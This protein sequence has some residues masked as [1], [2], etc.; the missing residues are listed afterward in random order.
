[1]DEL[2]YIDSW[3]EAAACF[4]RSDVDFFADN[5]NATSRAIETCTGCPV[6]DECLTWALET[7]QRDGVWGGYTPTQRHRIRHHWLK[8]IRRAS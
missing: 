8:E 4:D 6:S 2:A 7:N 3:R 5:R 1:M